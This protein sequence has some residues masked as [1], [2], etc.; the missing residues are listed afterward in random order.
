MKLFN[1]YFDH[2]MLGVQLGVLGKVYVPCSRNKRHG[3]KVKCKENFVLCRI[4]TIIGRLKSWLTLQIQILD[5]R[6]IKYLSLF[7]YSQR[8]G[9]SS[10]SLLVARSLFLSCKTFSSSPSAHFFKAQTMIA[11]GK[12][13]HSC[14][15]HNTA[16]TS[17]WRAKMQLT[18]SRRINC[19]Y[20]A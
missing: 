6:E 19:S 9:Y 12:Q 2:L 1:E 17:G 13:A 5:K 18:P 20:I 15:T 7:S 16:T 4:F 3:K 14:A 8:D 11:D 10:P